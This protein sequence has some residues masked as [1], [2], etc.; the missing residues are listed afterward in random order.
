MNKKVGI[1]V[2]G[3]ILLIIAGFVALK[4]MGGTASVEG[5]GDATEILTVTHTLGETPVAKNPKKVVVFELG[6]L[7]A[8]QELGLEEVVAAVP[9]DSLTSYLEG[10][11]TEDIVNVGSVKEPDMEKI[12]GVQPDLIIIGGRQASLYEKLSEIAPTIS[13]AIDNTQYI[14]SFR[15]NMTLIGELFGVEKEVETRLQAIEEKMAIVAEKVKAED[16]NALITLVNDGS[17]NAYGNN[18]RFSFIND[19]GFGNVDTTLEDATHGQT[20]SFEYIL[21]KNPE[22]LFVLDR[23]A[24]MGDA[25]PAKEII[26]NELV[27]KTQAYEKGQIVYLSPEPWYLSGGGFTST[28]LMLEDIAT[29]IG[30][31][32]Q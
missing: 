15:D 11:N 20:I 29:A 9:T 17:V 4:G 25:T 32:I 8:L 2:G 14:N 23:G 19:L 13:M 31:E 12:Y 18:S 7:D 26:E 30:A 22:F 1:I 10:F 21:E 24:I 3:I 28:Q 27:K 5:A 6:I 16:A